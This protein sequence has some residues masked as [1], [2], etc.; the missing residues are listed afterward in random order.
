MCPLYVHTPTC[1]VYE[2][3]ILQGTPLGIYQFS[4]GMLNIY[5][6]FF[7]SSA[8]QN[9]RA[10]PVETPYSAAALAL[11]GGKYPP[12]SLSVPNELAYPLSSFGVAEFGYPSYGAYGQRLIGGP[13]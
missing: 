6:S 8:A 3:P 11:Q 4:T 5:P 9:F 1:F 7:T 13:M 10:L 12:S 2:T